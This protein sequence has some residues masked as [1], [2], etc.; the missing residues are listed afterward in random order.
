MAYRH[1]RRLGARDLVARNAA[2]A[3]YTER[4]PTTP[5]DDVQRAVGLMI[6]AVARDHPQWLWRGVGAARWN[7]P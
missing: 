6:S 3:V 1:I 5:L 4:H 7:P 2:E